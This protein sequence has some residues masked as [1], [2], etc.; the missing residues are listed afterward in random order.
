M[1][2]GQIQGALA[3]VGAVQV[4][5]GLSGVVGLILRYIGPVCIAVVLTLLGLSPLRTAAKYSA[6]HWG[7]AFM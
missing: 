1:S 5:I 6:R 2:Y 4:V 7:V 3:V